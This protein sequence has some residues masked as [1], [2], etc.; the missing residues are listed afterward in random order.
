VFRPRRDIEQIEPVTHVVVV[1]SAARR[2]ASLRPIVDRTPLVSGTLGDPVGPFVVASLHARTA[3]RPAIMLKARR[4]IVTPPHPAIART[5]STPRR[6]SPVLV[7][8]GAPVTPVAP[9]PHPAIVVPARRRRIATPTP[10]ELTTRAAHTLAIPP[11]AGPRVAPRRLA[12]PAPVRLRT[13][14]QAPPSATPARLVTPPSHRPTV[15][16]AIVARSGKAA[17]IAPGR[18]TAPPARPLPLRRSTP[19]VGAGSRPSAPVAPPRI[20]LIARPVPRRALPHAALAFRTAVPSPASTTAPPLVWFV[21]PPRPRPTVRPAIAQRT[22][23]VLHGTIATPGGPILP[24][25][26]V[27]AA[28]DWLR[29]Y[30]PVSVPS[31]VTAF[32]EQYAS[33]GLKKLWTDKAEGSPKLPYMVVTEVSETVD[34]ESPDDSGVAHGFGLGTLQL[35]VFAATKIQ[36]RQLGELVASCLKDAPLTFADGVLMELRPAGRYFEV[37]DDVAAG[38]ATLYHRI[39]DFQYKVQRAV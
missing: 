28:L 23:L 34:Y 22:A 11:I 8:R 1:Q 10:I 31:V 6:G 38:S 37:E 7:L 15:R 25:D 12:T 18:P 24:D 14:S 9:L 27:A 3:A 39:I 36:A 30:P 2:R 4:G 5:S 13:N 19:I 17:P 35:S 16:P 32:G 33:P 20:E 29:L 26:L 21:A